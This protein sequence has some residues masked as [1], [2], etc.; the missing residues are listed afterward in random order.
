MSEDNLS[1][2]N[3]VEASEEVAKLY[4]TY[5][6]SILLDQIESNPYQPRKEFNQASLAELGQSMK[7]VG[8]VQP[9][10]V[11]RT[12]EGGFQLIDGERRT[13]AARLIGWESI[14]AV[15]TTGVTDVQMLEFAVTANDQREDMNV[16]DLAQ[17]WARLMKEAGYSQ[18]DLASRLGKHP[19]AISNGIRILK[20]PSSVQLLVRSGKLSTAHAIA[21]AKFAST[22]KACERIAAFSI[23][24]GLSSH[25]IERTVPGYVELV[26]DGMAVSLDQA[27]FDTRE[28]CARCPYKAAHKTRWGMVC[29][30]PK[31]FVELQKQALTGKV[32]PVIVPDETTPVSVP[33]NRDNSPASEA[34]PDVQSDLFP[35]ERRDSRQNDLLQQILRALDIAERTPLPE[36]RELAVIMCDS[37]K[38]TPMEDIVA[39]V[40]RAG[41]VPLASIAAL[42]PHQW[43]DGETPSDIGFE[44]MWKLLDELA[45][46]E[47]MV[48]ISISL[49]ATLRRDL[50]RTIRRRR[51]PADDRTLVSWFLRTSTQRVCRT[52]GCTEEEPSRDLLGAPCSWAS[53]DLC[54]ICATQLGIEPPTLPACTTS[55]YSATT[56]V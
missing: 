17:G 39:A 10:T 28:T 2:R 47:P 8:L 38:A 50:R 22:A 44:F 37:I 56:G 45:E 40:D 11:R 43:A 3:D 46:L 13:R 19:S 23:E 54:S 32:T 15:V 30:K 18:A 31:H 53:T 25:D 36:S 41:L 4:T 27:R 6:S 1:T 24:K 51:K 5:R 33:A 49:E 35:T 52:C 20:L 29:L 21:L 12:N 55:T 48:L 7:E 42:D 26:R 34:A 14:P 16:L 9:I